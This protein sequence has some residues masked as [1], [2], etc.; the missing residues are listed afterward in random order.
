MAEI[1]ALDPPDPLDPLPEPAPELLPREKLC[2]HGPGVLKSE[3]L[4]AVILG[5]GVAGKNVFELS[6]EIAALLTT[7]PAIPSVRELSA[8]KGLG[9]AKAAQVVACLELSSRFLLATNC[10]VVKTPEDCVKHIA[11][12]KHEPQEVFIMVSL[13]SANR[14]INKHELTRGVVDHTPIHPR[15]AFIKAI[16][17]HAV[18][19]IF[20]HNHPSG[21]LTPSRDDLSTTKTLCSAGALLGIEVAD[22]LIIGPSGWKSIRRDR[23]GIFRRCSF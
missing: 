19:V 8:I 1:L 2:K 4:L 14:I 9:M 21:S 23:P 7:L 16:Q 18:S 12:I 13:N 20:A 17:D 6:K 3:E 5:R 15:E 10:E 22:H 11:F